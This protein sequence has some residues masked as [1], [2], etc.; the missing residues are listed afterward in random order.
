MGDPLV[1]YAFI[2][3]GQLHDAVQNQ[4]PAEAVRLQDHQFLEAG[5]G[6][7]YDHPGHLEAVGSVG[8]QIFKK[9]EVF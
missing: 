9:P 5:I 1:V 3:F 6:F 2:L 4:D 8:I 7:G